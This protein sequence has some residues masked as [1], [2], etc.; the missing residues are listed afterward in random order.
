V[1]DFF[2]FLENAKAS[3][4]SSKCIRTRGFDG[5]S[6]YCAPKSVQLIGAEVQV[7][8]A[9]VLGRR[10]CM[11]RI[12]VLMLLSCIIV[13]PGGGLVLRIRGLMLTFSEVEALLCLRQNSLGPSGE[14]RLCIIHFGTY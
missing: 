4:L 14:P 1:A 2:H 12:C 7:I 8:G 6:H 13:Q 11:L 10:N 9:P 3:R 5:V